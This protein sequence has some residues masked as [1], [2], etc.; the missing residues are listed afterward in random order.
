MSQRL[1][2]GEFSQ[3][4]TDAPSLPQGNASLEAMY[5]EHRA[6]RENTRARRLPKRPVP[7]PFWRLLMGDEHGNQK[8]WA[9]GIMDSLCYS[10][11]SDFS[12]SSDDDLTAVGATSSSSRPR[13]DDDVGFSGFRWDVW[14]KFIDTTEQEQER[15][16][17]ELES[18]RHPYQRD[19]NN[20]ERSDAAGRV[21]PVS[22]LSQRVPCS[23]QRSALLKHLGPVS[24]TPTLQMIDAALWEFASYAPGT[25]TASSPRRIERQMESSFSRYLCHGLA[26]L[27]GLDSTTTTKIVTGCDT[28]AKFLVVSRRKRPAPAAAQPLS[29][30]L[31]ESQRL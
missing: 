29:M 14:E 3:G 5:G 26:Q 7:G 28:P 19:N 23:R 27:Y 18:L 25:P 9:G 2:L 10:G 22:M 30:W 4:G 16:I 13:Y 24:V 31:E 6:S 20:T 17:S 12:E 1:R 15:L 21:D 11:I 8:G